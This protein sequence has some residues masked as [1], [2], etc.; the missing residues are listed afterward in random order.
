MVLLWHWYIHT[1]CWC[2]LTRKPYLPMRVYMLP[3]PL[4]CPL[5]LNDVDCWL[6]ARKYMNTKRKKLT[7]LWTTECCRTSFSAVSKT[8]CAAFIILKGKICHYWFAMLKTLFIVATLMLAYLI[9]VKVKCITY[10]ILSA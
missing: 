10:K 2:M 7:Q 9:S 8:L 4:L 6:A 5:V 1:I 3:L